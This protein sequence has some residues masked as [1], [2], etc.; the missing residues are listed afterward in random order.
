MNPAPDTNPPPRRRVGLLQRTVLLGGALTAAMLALAVA[1]WTM[2]GQVVHQASV[3]GEGRVPQLER[4][5][6]LELDVTRASLLLRHAM[7]ARTP[8]ERQAALDEV[9]VRKASLQAT[10]AEFGRAMTD[11]DGRRAYEPLPGLMQA[12]G[13]AADSTVALV[14]AGRQAE[15]FTHLVDHAVPARNNLLAP[16]EAE[17]RRQLERLGADLGLVASQAGLSR[18]TVLGAVALVAAG[19]A[20]FAA[21]AVRVLRQLGAEPDALK[22]VADAVAAGDLTTRIELR[23]GDTGSVMAALSAMTANLDRVVRGVRANAEG[24]ATASSQIASGNA[25]LSRRTESQ[26]ASL[27]QTASSMEQLGATVRRNADNA[28]QA[29]QLAVASSESAGSG[30]D[31]V[32]EV[33]RTM[34]GISESSRRIADIIGVI[35]GIAFQTNIL[36][37][38]AAVEAA[39]AGEQGR[40]FAVVAG[41]VRNLAQRSGTAARE[42]K[43]LIGESVERVQQGAKLVDRAGDSMRGIVESIRRVT[44]IVGEISAAS[45]EQSRGVAQVGAAVTD[46]DRATQQNAALVEQSAAAAASLRQQSQHLVQSVSSFRLA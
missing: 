15:A 36:A 42:I 4:V 35:D 26:A 44:D 33:V 2:M 38:N 18:T 10:L 20:V 11:A 41:E 40:G 39:R 37:L 19:L 1:V 45:D 23:P 21:F 27:E 17:K 24:V 25:D 14:V 5:A 22:T 28:R 16:L 34:E 8:A 46:L 32:R 3:V 6:Q 7:L 31:T 29:N 30:G 13:A 43:A 9:G 12:F